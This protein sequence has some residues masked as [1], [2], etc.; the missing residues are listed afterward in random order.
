M[1]PLIFS[2]LHFLYLWQATA[3]AEQVPAIQK[4]HDSKKFMQKRKL[5]AVMLGLR[6]AYIGIFVPDIFVSR[7][8]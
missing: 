5:P 1:Q 7:S 2:G 8:S 6:C 4:N 3:I